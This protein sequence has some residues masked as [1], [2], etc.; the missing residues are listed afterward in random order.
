MFLTDRFET[1]HTHRHLW[2]RHL[3]FTY[4]NLALLRLVR[5]AVATYLKC[6]QHLLKLQILT[7][8]LHVLLEVCKTSK[9]KTCDQNT[10]QLKTVL[11]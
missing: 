10:C 4:V 3:P 5:H 11:E 9:I 7:E 8:L 1:E 2:P 6:W